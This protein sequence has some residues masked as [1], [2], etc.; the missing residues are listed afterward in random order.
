MAGHP[1]RRRDDDRHG[2]PG[3]GGPHQRFGRRQDRSVD[4]PEQASVSPLPGGRAGRVD[5]VH[6]AARQRHRAV[7]PG[8]AAVRGVSAADRQLGAARTAGRQGRQ[9]LV[10]RE[11]RRPD[12][13]GRS[14]DREGHRVQDAQSQGA[15]PAHHRVPSRRA[16][17]LHGAGRQLRRHARSEVRRHQVDRSADGEFAALRRP[18]RLEGGAIF[19]SVQRQQDRHHRRQDDDDPRVRS[20]GCESAAAPDR[21]RQGRHRVVR[22]LRARLSRSPRSEDGQGR[23]VQVTRRRGFPPLRD[24]RDRGRRHLVRGDR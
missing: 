2:R 14:Q 20:A 22:R 16:D 12:R 24:R 8:D 1:A 19:R 6:R 23:G 21:D 15:R 13:Q 4:D 11:R 9:H 17:F 7:R 10:H 18:P 5:L 3:T